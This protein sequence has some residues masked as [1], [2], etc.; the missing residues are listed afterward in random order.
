VPSMPS[1]LECQWPAA[2][3]VVQLRPLPAER[4]AS[5]GGGRDL[6]ELLRR[7]PLARALLGLSVVEQC[8]VEEQPE[9]EVGLA[10]R[11][12]KWVTCGTKRYQP[13][14]TRHSPW[15]LLFPR[16]SRYA[17]TFIHPFVPSM[18][19]IRMRSLRPGESAISSA[20]LSAPLRC[21]HPDPFHVK[22]PRYRGTGNL[23]E[24]EC[25]GL[26]ATC[27]APAPARAGCPAPR[28]RRGPSLGS[29]GA[30]AS[31][32]KWTLATDGDQHRRGLGRVGSPVHSA[33]AR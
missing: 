13:V 10:R 11:G 12:T 25:E 22:R 14:V 1:R 29:A 2:P 18:Y 30:I 16:N 7:G 19:L 9:D 28:P 3:S 20:T 21:W 26:G 33:A 32:V 4:S 23:R 8:F 5:A 24:A 31:G 15:L 6:L 17:C 27:T